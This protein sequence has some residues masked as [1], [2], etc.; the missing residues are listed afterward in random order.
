MSQRVI[1]DAEARKKLL[2]GVNTVGD[3]V[4]ITMGPKGRAVLIPK[5]QPVFTLD[6]VTVAKSI[7]N[8]E[9]P[10]ED[11]G[12]QLVKRVADR[13]NDEAGDGT[14]TATLL[15]QQ[16]LNEGIRGVEQGMDPITLKRALEDAGKLVLEAVKKEKTEVK[17]EEQ[18]AAV[19]TISSRE[20]EI[21]DT[22]AGLYYKLGKDGIIT[23]EEVKTVGITSEL[24]EGM[25][26]DNG[27]SVPHFQTNVERGTATLE[28][29]YILVTGQVI[30][31][32]DDVV[33][34]LN[35]IVQTDS[36]SLLIVA[37]DVAGEALAT[38]VINKLKR[39]LNCLVVKAPGYGDSKRNHLEDIAAVTGAQFI[40]E[41]TGNRVETV[42]T[43]QLGRAERVVAYKN[44]TII[45]GGKGD[46]KAIK[47]RVAG[48][49]NDLSK[50]ETPFKKS[51]LEKRLAK[52][53]GKV[54]VVRVGDV[55]D[56]ASREKQYRIEDAINATKSAIEEGV[57]EGGGMALYRAADVL[58]KAIDKEKDPD[59][60]F[61]LQIVQRA[62]RQP[63]RQILE[64][65]GKN[66]DV[67]LAQ[68]YKVPETVIDPFK[69]E[70][71]ALELAISTVGLF[72]VTGAVVYDKAEKKAK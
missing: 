67:V 24:V 59:Y 60:R 26:L 56:E 69:V 41:E 9:D 25:Q 65:E 40:T 16:L 35:A 72:L 15:T 14:T 21:G 6:G 7:G 62:I 2:R 55:T 38:L 46:A 19:A 34:L 4:R 68:A 23:T 50:A 22:I 32:N 27:W 30:N 66:A 18:M 45:V 31:R 48:I 17:T 39:V 28:K 11:M 52:L 64:N 12:V 54:A 57:V 63:A 20:K 44:R 10:V 29:P 5:V 43:E 42:T 49:K 8:V 37:E 47:E 51:I 71:V 1:F 13:T 36:K 61:G 70:R 53:N 33:N 58:Q 3:A